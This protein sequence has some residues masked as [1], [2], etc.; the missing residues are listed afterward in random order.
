MRYGPDQIGVVR[1]LTAP[2]RVRSGVPLSLQQYGEYF[3]YQNSFYP[4]FGLGP[5]YSDKKL[6]EIQQDIRGYSGAGY[7]GNGIVFA[8][9]LSRLQVFSQARFQFRRLQ[10]G[11]PGEYF[12][13]ADLVPLEEPEP[14]RTTSD[15][16]ARMELDI[17][18]AGNSFIVRQGDYLKRLRPDWCAIVLSGY[19]EE[20]PDAVVEGYAYWP[21]GIASGNDPVGYV[22][23]QVAHYAPLPDPL[24]CYRG[25]SWMTPIVREIMADS[26]FR[27]H[28]I[29]FLQHGGSHNFLFQ[30][31]KASMTQER[32]EEFVAAYR[33]QH[34]GGSNVAKSIFLRAAVDATPLGT[35]FTD[36]DMKAIIGAGETRIAAAAGVPPIVAGFSE[37][38]ASATYSNYGQA[39][40]RF[41]DGTIRWLWQ[42]AAASLQT[43]IPTPPAAQLWYDDRDIP[44]LQ[45]DIKDRAEVQ[46][47]QAAATKS[48]IDA[49]YEPAS[50]VDAVTSGDLKRLQHTGLF[51]VQLQPAGAGQPSNGTGDP[52]AMPMLPPG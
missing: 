27:D 32:F 41:V 2:E 39:R 50:V 25:M 42:N 33:G 13:N 28:K 24:A 6:E 52:A 16:L 36:S 5:T 30:I 19:G 8:C 40:R 45:E 44:A 43:L 9:I 17:S 10:S 4:L 11:R 34:E 3:Q 20:D 38:L 14:G 12:G 7:M 31:D 37:G 26:G 21:G 1:D 15:L 35:N 51:S 48:L 47:M 22:R 29:D 49:G 46:Q 23:E 18:L